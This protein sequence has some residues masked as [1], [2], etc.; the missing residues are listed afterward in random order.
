MSKERPELGGKSFA[1]CVNNPDFCFYIG[2]TF[3]ALTMEDLRCLT[4]RGA[5][6]FGGDGEIIHGT[7][8]R[9][10]RPVLLRGN[11]EHVT[12]KG[13][14]DEFGFRSIVVFKTAFTSTHHASRTSFR[15][16]TKLFH[17]AAQGR[18]P[19]ITAGGLMSYF[20]LIVFRGKPVL[21]VLPM[22]V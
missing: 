14:R 19:K 18:R 12:M 5:A 3:C 22:G 4:A 2:G 8:K 6:K 11:G 10:N 20:Q 15:D 13:A 16:G 21:P 7:E 1:E 9:I 17:S